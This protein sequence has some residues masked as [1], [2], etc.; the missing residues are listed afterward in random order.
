VDE[1]LKRMVMKDRHGQKVVHSALNGIDYLFS[2][3]APH[4]DTKST[5]NPEHL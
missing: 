1:M 2:N 4:K 3:F 5:K